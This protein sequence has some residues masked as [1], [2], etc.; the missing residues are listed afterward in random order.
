VAVRLVRDA[1]HHRAVK[2]WEIRDHVYAVPAS[3]LAETYTF[4]RRR[5]GYRAARDLVRDLLASPTVTIHQTTDA[6]DAATWA[7]I[8]EFAGVPLS[9][10]DA[11]VVALARELGIESVFSF[12]DDFRRA[13]L[14][15]VPE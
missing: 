5:Q 12:D 11:S 1:N 13:G 7:V 4:L 10:V 9:Y 3:V 2:F 15:L 8:D 6:R 14:R